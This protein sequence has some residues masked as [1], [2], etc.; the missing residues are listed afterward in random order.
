MFGQVWL[1]TKQPGWTEK[2]VSIKFKERQ[3]KKN[4]ETKTRQATHATD[5]FR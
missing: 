1:K 4:A 2:F 5:K 3:K